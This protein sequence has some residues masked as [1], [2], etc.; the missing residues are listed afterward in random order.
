MA[1]KKYLDLS[2]LSKLWQLIKSKIPSTYASSQSAGGAADK[3]VSIPF[4]QVDSTSTATA[5]TAK[6][7]T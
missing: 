4:G 5:F 1:D 7:S 6:I 2:G 3:A